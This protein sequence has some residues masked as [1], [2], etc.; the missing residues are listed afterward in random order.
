M[1]GFYTVEAATG[2][3]ACY[4]GGVVDAVELGVEGEEDLEGGGEF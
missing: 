2:H 4:A 3:V 1:H